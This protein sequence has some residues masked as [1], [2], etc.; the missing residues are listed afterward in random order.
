[1]SEQR[2][3]DD[4]EEWGRRYNTAMEASHRRHIEWTEAQERRAVAGGA[5]R[6]GFDTSLA[7]WPFE[8]QIV[9]PPSK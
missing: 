7:Y 9:F 2:P 6:V 4:K 1:M 5:H 3:P 8:R